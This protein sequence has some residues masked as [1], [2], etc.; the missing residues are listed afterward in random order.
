MELTR[1]RALIKIKPV[2]L[3]VYLA[4]YTCGVRGKLYY[5]NSHQRKAP[6]NL[7]E[8]PDD[9]AFAESRFFCWFGR[10]IF[11]ALNNGR[12]GIQIGFGGRGIL[13]VGGFLV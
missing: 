2:C 6:L 3:S 4:L 12:V 7:I 9:P 5:G 13:G 10:E 1:L 8:L 11:G